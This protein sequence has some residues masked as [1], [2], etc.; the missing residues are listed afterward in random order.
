MGAASLDG[1][2]GPESSAN[3]LC[4]LPLFNDT[5]FLYTNLICFDE[6]LQWIKT[7]MHINAIQ[8]IPL[9]Y[10]FDKVINVYI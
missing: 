6:I 9:R 5:D 4:V 10:I 8:R 2:L 7:T 3:H 1:I